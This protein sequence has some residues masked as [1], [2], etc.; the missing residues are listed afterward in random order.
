MQVERERGTKTEEKEVQGLEGRGKSVHKSGMMNGKR[1]E[2]PPRH[3]P[4][5]DGEH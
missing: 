5:A 3:A 2:A 1:G 4:R